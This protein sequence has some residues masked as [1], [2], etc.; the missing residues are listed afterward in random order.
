MDNEANAGKVAVFDLAI[1]AIV[2]EGECTDWVELQLMY[3]ELR[4]HG[5]YELIIVRRL[6]PVVTRFERML[7]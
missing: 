2:A 4:D 7:A 6:E 1:Q 5:E 3:E